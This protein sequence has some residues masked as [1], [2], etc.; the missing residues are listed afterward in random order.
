[1]SAVL[2]YFIMHV[3]KRYFILFS[4]EF[5]LCAYIYNLLLY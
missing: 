5:D 1:M 3:I 2:T 4:I